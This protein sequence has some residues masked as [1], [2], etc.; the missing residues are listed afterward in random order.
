MS[1]TRHLLRQDFDD[2]P[3][4]YPGV[5]GQGTGAGQRKRSDIE[6]LQ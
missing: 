4:E 3:P 6:K 2:L 1:L 5:H